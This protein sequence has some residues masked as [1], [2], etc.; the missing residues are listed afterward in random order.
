MPSRVLPGLIVGVLLAGGARVATADDSYRGE[1]VAIDLASVAVVFGGLAVGE[2]HATLPIMALGVI[3][4]EIGA[5]IDHAAHGHLGRAGISLSAHVALPVIGGLV[6][7]STKRGLDAIL[8]MLAGVVLGHLAATAVD[9][10]IADGTDEPRM[11]SFG[12][13]F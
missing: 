6:G 9:V 1:V 13:R 12:A 3:A 8:P 4:A 7:M 2:K 11:M 5:P 10:Y